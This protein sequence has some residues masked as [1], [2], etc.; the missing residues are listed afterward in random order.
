[1][2]PLK[3]LHPFIVSFLNLISLSP[4]IYKKKKKNTHSS[5]NRP[6]G[7]RFSEKTTHL[8][9]LHLIKIYFFSQVFSVFKNNSF[10]PITK[11]SARLR[12]LSFLLNQRLSISQK[13][14]IFFVS[15]LN[16]LIQRKYYNSSAANNL[17]TKKKQKNVISVLFYN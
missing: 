14:T 16:T 5:Q 17:L 9:K 6:E 13:N 3:R 10:L 12:L 1:M 7:R 15:F 4:L 2:H 11:S 8:T